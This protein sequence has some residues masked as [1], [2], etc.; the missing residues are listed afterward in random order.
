MPWGIVT[1]AIGGMICAERQI[2]NSTNWAM[3]LLFYTRSN[4]NGT[5]RDTHGNAVDV[6]VR[7]CAPVPTAYMAPPTM[8]PRTMAPYYGASAS[9]PSGAPGAAAVPAPTAAP[10][11]I[12]Q[13]GIASMPGV[14]RLCIDISGAYGGAYATSFPLFHPSAKVAFAVCQ[15]RPGIYLLV[16]DLATLDLRQPEV[17]PQRA[18]V[19]GGVSYANTKRM[20]P[21]GEIMAICHALRTRTGAGPFMTV[22]A[23]TNSGEGRDGTWR[24]TYGAPV[25]MQVSSFRMC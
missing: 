20:L 19:L 18:V 3:I 13:A 11:T 10:S 9:L 24:T 15:A 23:C 22:L 12:N 2:R 17:D 8:A 21:R 5:W 4:G 25:Q 7:K 16:G 1:S 14:R 6:A